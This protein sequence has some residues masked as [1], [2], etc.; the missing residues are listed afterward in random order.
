MGSFG[1]F[2]TSPSTCFYVS[3]SSYQVDLLVLA[4]NP[5]SRAKTY[6]KFGGRVPRLTTAGDLATAKRLIAEMRAFRKAHRIALEAVKAG[7]RRVTFSAGTGKMHFIYGYA[8]EVY[9][10]LAAA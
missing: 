9:V 6:E 1:G 2:R 7:K 3:K 8:R 4:T 10:P 5:H